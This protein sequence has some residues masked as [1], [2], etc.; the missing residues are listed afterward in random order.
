VLI[1]P[2]ITARLG[3]PVAVLGS[4][5]SGAAAAQWLV[6]LGARPVIYDERFGANTRFGPADAAGHDLVVY[7]PGFAQGHPWLRTA[8]ASGARCLG[9]LDFSALFWPSPIVAV[10]GT[11]GKTTLTEFLVHAHKRDGRAAVAV[12]NVGYPLANVLGQ[13]EGHALL[14][15]CEV[16]SFQSE[17]MEHFAPHNLLWTNIAEDHLDRHGSV[18]AYF[19]AKYRLVERLA[20]PR[21]FVG[22]S[23]AQYACCVGLSLPAFVVVASRAEVEGKVPPESVFASYPQRENYALARRYW[24]A[25]GWEESRLEEA[26][27]SFVLAGHRLA[28]VAEVA[29]VEW[30]NDSKGTNFH[31]VL[32]AL[33]TF[34]DVGIHWMGGGLSKGGDLAAFAKALAGRIRSASLIGESAP[35]MRKHLEEQGVLSHV[36][37]SLPAAVAA[38]AQ[39]ARPGERVLFS[40]GFASF[41][42]FKSYA[43]RGQIF[44]QAVLAIKNDAMARK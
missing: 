35:H 29:G 13:A 2:D 18:E 10:T 39:L 17:D 16:S 12:G 7:S 11:N 5:V 33:E 22:E 15:V 3:R 31:A 26:A 19:R 1:P 4:G 28:K 23:V 20:S 32:S 42:M 27:S 44:E 37:A 8:R 30:W 6:Q 14:P 36:Y 24:L 38:A 41:D 21:L 43:E 9:E 25:A 40:P 34:P